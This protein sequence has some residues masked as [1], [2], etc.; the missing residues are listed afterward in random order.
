MTQID[1]PAFYRSDAHDD[2]V[3]T[4]PIDGLPIVRGA[5]PPAGMPRRPVTPHP[6][7]PLPVQSP[8]PPR[9][10]KRIA[11]AVLV[12]AVVGAVLFLVLGTG[13]F[14]GAVADVALPTTVHQVTYEVTTAKGTRIAATY[15]RSRTDGLASTSVSG[16]RSPWRADAEVS[17]VMGPML[18]AS[19]SPEPGR[20]SRSDTITCTVVEDGVQI[21]RNSADGEDAMVTCTS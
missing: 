20:V 4:G 5:T 19:L 1:R 18:T 13:V 11:I 9:R 10:S 2:A 3:L 16:V 6:S 12:V 17:G 21:A 14:A 15:S 7:S 8:R